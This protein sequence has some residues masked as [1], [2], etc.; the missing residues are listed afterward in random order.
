VEIVRMYSWAGL[1]GLAF[2]ALT[3]VLLVSMLYLYKE[4]L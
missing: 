1:N 3:S 2:G 4:V